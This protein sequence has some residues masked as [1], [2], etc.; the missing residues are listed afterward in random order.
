MLFFAEVKLMS[1]PSELSVACE[2]NAVGA[3]RVKC[4]KC[5]RELKCSAEW[6]CTQDRILCD[7]C[8]LGLLNPNTQSGNVE[9]I[10]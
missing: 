9:L 5:F 3:D 8:Y 4:S 6:I 7:R 10:D 1:D 2:E